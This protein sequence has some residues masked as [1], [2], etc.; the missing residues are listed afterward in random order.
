MAYIL[1][2]S[3]NFVLPREKVWTLLLS[4]SF[5]FHIFAVTKIEAGWYEW[6]CLWVQAALKNDMGIVQSQ[7]CC[8]TW[9]SSGWIWLIMA[10]PLLVWSVPLFKSNTQQNAA[11]SLPCCAVGMS[12]CIHVFF[13]VLQPQWKNL[14][15]IQALLY[16]TARTGPVFIFLIHN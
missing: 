13:L 8:A 10:A 16:K 2:S 12:N 9:G 3:F 4:N 5:F 6:D 14:R 11:F 7:K 15:V 1:L